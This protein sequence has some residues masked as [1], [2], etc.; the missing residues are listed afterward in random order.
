MKFKQWNCDIFKT[1]YA[2][3]R[4]AIKLYDS[5]HGDPIATATVNLPDETLPDNH[6]FIKNWSENEGILD[7]LVKANYIKPTGR[8]VNTGFVT[9][10]EAELCS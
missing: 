7:C 1:K 10:I 2:N 5:E 3:G 6:V 8:T 9:A 4:T